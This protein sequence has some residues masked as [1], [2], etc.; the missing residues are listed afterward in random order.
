MNKRQEKR[1]IS[2]RRWLVERYYRDNRCHYCGAHTYLFDGPLKATVD[3]KVPRADRR[4]NHWTNYALAC[5][6]C[7]QE[8]GAMPYREYVTWKSRAALSETPSS[9]SQEGGDGHD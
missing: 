6:T 5:W 8:K 7:N 3:H 9:P 1:R 2:A 4:W